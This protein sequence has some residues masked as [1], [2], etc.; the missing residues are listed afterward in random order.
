MNLDAVT[1]I[2]LFASV[3]KRRRWDVARLTDEVEVPSGRRLI[4]QGGYAQEFFIV[5]EGAADVYRD[6]EL[7]ATVEAGEF[8]GEVGL[9]G[10][11][12]ERNATVVARSPMRLVVLARNQFRELLHAVPAIAG[13]IRRAAALRA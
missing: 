13:P 11:R 1:A 10:A 7:V 12:W 8:F 5:V 4:R 3:P 2:P 9:L 6:G